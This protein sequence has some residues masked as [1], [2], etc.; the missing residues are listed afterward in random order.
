ML[1]ARLEEIKLLMRYAVPSED[2]EEAFAVLHRYEADPVA[3]NLLHSF[4]SFLPEGQDDA[5]LALH[6]LSLKEGI[7]LFGVA[8]AADTYL[9]LAGAEQAEFLGPC[10]NGI[11][12][13][14]VLE[15]FGIA[16]REESIRAFA[17]LAPYAEYTPAARDSTLCPVCAAAEGE[18]HTLGCPVEVCPWCDGQLTACNCRFTL[19][20][21]QA[22]SAEKDL[23]AFLEL[24]ETKGRIPFDAAHQRPAYPEEN[25]DASA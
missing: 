25:P 22:L 5:V 11:W 20:G 6:L 24:L 17:D 14:E 10:A 1:N 19:T 8:T 4:Y 12:D 23:A 13:S 18:L 9:Y 16:S 3:L 2:E 7:F 15:F 21:K